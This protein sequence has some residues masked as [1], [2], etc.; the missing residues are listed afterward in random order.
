MENVVVTPMRSVPHARVQE[1]H[2]ESAPKTV[3]KWTKEEDDRLVRQIAAF[4]QNLHHCFVL[5][6]E[7][8]DRTPAA[9]ASHWYTSL[10]KRD[11]VLIFIS[12]TRGLIAMNR[13]NGNFRPCNITIWKK[14]IH[15]V[16]SLFK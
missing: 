8:I 4:P 12:A 15:I 2:T 11:D 7:E 6:S 16:K 13:K 10:S 14:I 9:C 1:Q 5:V 3:R